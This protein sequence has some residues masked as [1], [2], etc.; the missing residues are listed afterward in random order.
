[1][2]EQAIINKRARERER[3]AALTK[4]ILQV[5]LRMQIP[6]LLAYLATHEA[7]MC[8]F[9]PTCFLLAVSVSITKALIHIP[10][11]KN[12]D[13]KQTVVSENII[14]RQHWE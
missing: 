13:G 8:V 10:D 2:W 4:S 11:R 7:A 6:I 14:E 5:L 3:I 12:A 1:M 9:E